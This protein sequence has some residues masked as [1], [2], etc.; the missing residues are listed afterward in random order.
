MAHPRLEE[1]RQRA[2]FRCGYCGVSESDTGGLLTV[3]HFRPSS[4]RG[5][6]SGENLVYACFRCNLNKLD[7][8]PTDSDRRQGFRVL[9]PY[10]D[11]LSTHLC[12]EPLTSLLSGLTPTG[13]FH[14]VLLHL[15]RPELVEY[16]RRRGFLALTQERVVALQLYLQ[17]SERLIEEQRRYIAL[18][19][20]LT[21]LA[22][23]P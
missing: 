2:Q 17:E 3:D 4:A 16:R 10:Q 19:E 11:D 12:E 9:H 18:L 22:P 15:N 13:S 1:V 20:Q 14:I 8:W 6:D 7:F 23:G 21:R 5:D